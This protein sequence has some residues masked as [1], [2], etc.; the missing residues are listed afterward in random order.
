[1]SVQMEHAEKAWSSGCTSTL[2]AACRS[3]RTRAA[4]ARRGLFFL[5]SSRD[6]TRTP[7]G[8]AKNGSS[9]RRTTLMTSTSQCAARW[10]AR[11]STVRMVPPMPYACMIRKCT[12]G[13]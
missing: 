8:K 6:V 9:R 3:L 12:A 2:G 7:S 11:F 4:R 5:W 10:P 13:R 1:M